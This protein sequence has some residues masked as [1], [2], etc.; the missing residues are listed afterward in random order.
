M[1]KEKIAKVLAHRGIGSRRGAEGLV[2]AGKVTVNGQR[3]DNVAELVDPEAII[4]VEGR[5]LP[6]TETPRLWAFY[7]PDGCLTTRHDPEGRPTLY[8]YLPSSL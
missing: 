2:K 1:K 3:M 8:D 7:K 4:T 5:T 6:P